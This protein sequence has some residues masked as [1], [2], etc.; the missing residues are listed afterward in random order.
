MKTL[1]RGACSTVAMHDEWSA[2]QVFGGSVSFVSSVQGMC[3]SNEQ[4]DAHMRL[5][6]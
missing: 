1:F 3:S 5:M 4:G 6:Y 2:R